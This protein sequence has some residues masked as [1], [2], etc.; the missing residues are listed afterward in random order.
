M[1][2]SKKTRKN[3]KPAVKVQDLTPQSNPKG[4]VTARKAG[5][6]QEEYLKVTMTDILISS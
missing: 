3:A 2:R 1:A 6:Q 5:G 4:G